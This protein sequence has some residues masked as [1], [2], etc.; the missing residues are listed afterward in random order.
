M[1]II[2]KL[3]QNQTAWLVIHNENDMYYITS[4]KSRDRY[5][6]YKKLDSGFEKIATGTDPLD[7]EEKYVWGVKK[8]VGK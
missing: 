3:P 6:L 2:K 1:A 7:L 8:N 5:F 4:S